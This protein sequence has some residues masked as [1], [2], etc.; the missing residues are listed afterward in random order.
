[1][2]AAEQERT[3]QTCSTANTLIN[4]Q[5]LNNFETFDSLLNFNS[6]TTTNSNKSDS[7][8][9]SLTTFYSKPNKGIFFLII[10]KIKINNLKII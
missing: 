8:I 7:N 10:N 2:L 6:T 9:D 4:N 3:F 5:N 1:M